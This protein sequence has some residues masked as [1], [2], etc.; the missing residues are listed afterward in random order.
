MLS[1]LLIGPDNGACGNYA[2]TPTAACS[3]HYGSGQAYKP[4]N[5]SAD[6]ASTRASH[7]GRKTAKHTTSTAAT[8]SPATS[9]PASG[10]GSVPTGPAQ[11]VQ[12]LLGGSG[13]STG[14]T[15]GSGTTPSA[16]QGLLNYLI[17]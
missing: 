11:I 17:K 3:A 7:H 2:T 6:T 15:G 4:T 5:A 8:T 1:V 10:T 12:K 9:P 16:L 14:T 13:P